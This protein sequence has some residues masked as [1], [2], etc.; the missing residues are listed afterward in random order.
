MAKIYRANRQESTCTSIQGEQEGDRTREMDG[1][2]AEGEEE[3]KAD[4]KNST[5]GEEATPPAENTRVNRET[6][7]ETGRT[8]PLE[9]PYDMHPTAELAGSR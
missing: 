5:M 7:T 9:V 2:Q 4:R 1:R 8:G 6:T 3:T